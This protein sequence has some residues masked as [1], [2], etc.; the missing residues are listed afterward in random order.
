M[1]STFSL[2]RLNGR[3]V[4]PRGL[5]SAAGT[6][7]RRTSQSRGIFPCR[8]VNCGGSDRYT[9]RHLVTSAGL[10]VR[11]RLRPVRGQAGGGDVRKE[12]WLSVDL[13]G[14]ILGV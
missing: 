6:C 12:Y 13:C 11:T 14:S 5:Y 9:E 3:S 10:L 2:G 4:P 1:I 8:M 7:L